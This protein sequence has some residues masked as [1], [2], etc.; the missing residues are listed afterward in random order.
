MH[1]RLL[2]V[3][4][5]PEALVASNIKSSLESC[6]TVSISWKKPDARG[7]PVHSYRVQRRDVELH[8]NTDKSISNYFYG[9]N[10]HPSPE[11]QWITV[12]N[13]GE[14]TFHDNTL[15]LGLTYKY[16]IQAWN[17]VGRSPWVDID[18][19]KL[20]KHQKCTK[21]AKTG[22]H[23]IFSSVERSVPNSASGLL[24]F[25]E[26]I[27]TF[28]SIISTLVYVAAKI[29]RLRRA[30]APSTLTATAYA[31]PIPW[32]INSINN[33]SKKIIGIHILPNPSQVNF[34]SHDES[35]KA[36]GLNGYKKSN[37]ISE[38]SE[39]DNPSRRRRKM[40]K[41]SS[42]RSMHTLSSN[43]ENNPKPRRRMSS[44]SLEASV[45]EFQEETKSGG[46][47]RFSM[48]KMRSLRKMS[49][50]RT[51]LDTIKSE[52]EDYSI[53]LVEE[54]RRNPSMNTLDSIDNDKLCNSC[55]K[56]Y[57]FGKR[58]KHHCARCLATFCHKHGRTTH[59]NFTSC[60]VPGD[61]VCNICLALEQQG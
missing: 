54:E 21:L 31:T 53:N 35:I 38:L 42:E 44:S 55:C 47:V 45:E 36:I 52:N 37:S 49:S 9:P 57:K 34:E 16:R 24:M 2:G 14:P 30:S 40:K 5:V 10:S 48:I 46:S 59:S 23:S 51:S 1:A 60:K 41:A 19:T 12:Y 56:P 27:V 7:F 6:S 25:V 28:V 39:T 29:M 18:I 4:T 17:S 61:C 13:G 8:S 20:L 50:K 32:L 58:Y 3:G 26:L 11:S 33:I 43:E 15:Q 22:S